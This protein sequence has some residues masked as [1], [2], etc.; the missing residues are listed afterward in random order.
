MT[1]FL[2]LVNEIKQNE[3]IEMQNVRGSEMP[4]NVYAE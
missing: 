2:L 4:E 3:D 1:V